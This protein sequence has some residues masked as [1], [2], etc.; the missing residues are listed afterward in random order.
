MQYI[1]PL[2][3]SSLLLLTIPTTGTLSWLLGIENIPDLWT[4]SG[5]SVIISGIAMI[6]YSEH[7]RSKE[8]EKTAGSEKDDQQN[9]KEIGIELEHAKMKYDREIG[10]RS[11]TMNVSL[12]RSPQSPL[13]ISSYLSSSPQYSPV[14]QADDEEG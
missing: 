12:S 6:T 2:L 8:R 3:F 13:S 9:E 4:V 14:E 5:G 7:Q 10:K 1:D 11:N